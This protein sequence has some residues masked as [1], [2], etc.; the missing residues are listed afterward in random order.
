MRIITIELHKYDANDNGNPNDEIPVTSKSLQYLRNYILQ[1][2]GYVSYGPEIRDDWSQYDYVPLTPEYREY[3]KFAHRL[4]SEGLLHDKTFTITTDAQMAQ[5]GI[6]GQLGCFVSAAPYIVTG[7]EIEDQYT[8]IAPVRAA[9][10]TGNKVH[11]HLG[12]FVPD[13]A[14]IPTRTPYVREVA[15]L[16]DILYSD[17][18]AQLISYGVEGE[19]WDWD[20][21]AHTSWTFHVPESW[22]GN[23]EQ[24]RA[25]ITPNVGTGAALYWKND[26]VGKMNDEIIHKLNEQ[27]SIYLPYLKMA[28]PYEI[29]LNYAEYNKITKIKAALDPQLEYMECCFIKGQDGYDPNDDA[30]YQ[31]YVSNLKGYQ[32]EELLQC[33]NDALNRYNERKNG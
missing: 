10:Y 5:Y 23:Q 13:G 2:Y 6:Q 21:E 27:S 25:T 15:R 4:Y 8:T 33:Y 3:L 14:C 11:T 7:Y 16:L 22:V 29:K 20:D 1:A 17:L 31:K 12:Y 19:N 30:S 26:F 9:T 32:C 28:E 24:Y 18:G